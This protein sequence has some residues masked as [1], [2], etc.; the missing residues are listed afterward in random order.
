MHAKIKQ[1][2]AVALPALLAGAG[3]STDPDRAATDDLRRSV[4]E[5]ARRESRAAAGDGDADLRSRVTTR[6]AGEVSFPPER[7]S[8]LERLAGPKSYETRGMPADPTVLIASRPDDIPISLE[9]TVRS[10]VERNLAVQSARLVPAVRSAEVVAAEA[11][12]DWT[13]YT[14]ADAGWINQPQATPLIGAAVLGSRVN[15]NRAVGFETGL[16]RPL[17]SGATLQIAQG[18]RYT[19][20]ASPGIAFDPDPSSS[21]FVDVGLAQPLLRGFGSDATQAE[22]RLAR[23]A[24]RDAVQSLHADVMRVATDAERAYWTLLA[25]R[26]GVQIA[27]RL[28]ERGIETRDVL[29]A[30]LD[31]D[32][33]PAQY[34]DAVARVEQRRSALLRAQNALRKASDA[35]KALINDPSAPLGGEALLVPVDSPIDEPIEFSLIDAVSSAIDRRPEV[36]RAALSIDNASI[37]QLAAD[38]AALPL[39]DLGFRTRFNGLGAKAGD[40]YGNIRD[41]EFVDYLLNLRFETPIGNRGPDALS[42]ARR[43]DRVR[44]VVDYRAA[45]QRT[46]LSVKNALRDVATNYRLIEQTRSARLAATENLRTL[47]IEE[48]TLKAMTPDFLDLK[49]RRQ[50]ALAQA[51]NEEIAALVDYNNALAELY[52]ATGAALVR[53]KI[54]FVA[55]PDGVSAGPAPVQ[56]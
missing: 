35:L 1:A 38:N 10:A 51:E 40:A 39:L 43:L 17:E 42:R 53:N 54:D 16:R 31:F 32:A 18:L 41:A 29:K 52:N 5:S 22:I 30:R 15:R 26:R 13:F 6:T 27:Q 23:N 34:S 49:L 28:L 21:A 12:F 20:N 55:P 4:I 36:R 37:R 8:E 11:R 24:E 46:V 45:V 48:Q 2:L 9:Q 47:L 14:G 19:D 56:R 50:D 25:A 44:A 33:K 7:L 3:C